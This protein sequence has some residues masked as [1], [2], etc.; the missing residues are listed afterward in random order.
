M[1]ATAWATLGHGPK[2]ASWARAFHHSRLSV[3][4]H[5]NRERTRAGVDRVERQERENQPGAQ[6]ID[7]QDECDDCQSR[8]HPTRPVLVGQAAHHLARFDVADA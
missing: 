4:Q 7:E 8:V 6:V 2:S 1:S 5:A 3:D